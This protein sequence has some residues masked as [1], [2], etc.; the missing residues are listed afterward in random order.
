M[1]QTGQSSRLADAQHGLTQVSALVG[2]W[3]VHLAGVA[4]EAAVTKLMSSWNDA[5]AAGD[6]SFS[7]DNMRS[8]LDDVAENIAYLR[9]ALG[10]R[11]AA[12][13]PVATSAP[14]PSSAQA[15]SLGAQLAATV[16]AEKDNT[17]DLARLRAAQQGA[18]AAAKYRA[19][20][21]A[22]DDAKQTIT[23][24]I[25]S[26]KPTRELGVMV[27]FDGSKRRHD[28]AYSALEL[29]RGLDL[30]TGK[31]SPYFPLWRA[32]S[33]WAHGQGL[34]P[35]WHS[36]WDGGGIHSWYVL[37]VKPPK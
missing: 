23:L 29:F 35:E 13:V 25:L 24:Q 1:T 22:Y 20:E 31:R 30:A 18:E 14:A 26:R 16:K 21:V 4:V 36:C 12:Q 10:R 9:M 6:P 17:E 5:I 19:V 28:A 34:E 2:S 7:R 11:T 3:P 37:R 15:Q 32:F 33:E 27:G 8:D